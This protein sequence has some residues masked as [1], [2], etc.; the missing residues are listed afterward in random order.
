M[1]RK[2]K[3]AQDPVRAPIDRQI[4]IRIIEDN[5]RTLPPKLKRHILQ[6][7]LRR[8]LH[9]LPPNHRRAS[10]RQFLDI[11]MRRHGIADGGAVS[12]ENVDYTWRETGFVDERGHAESGERGEFGGLEDDGVAASESGTDLPAHQHNCNSKPRRTLSIPNTQKGTQKE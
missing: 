7:R 3:N 8:P 10:E 12:D 4:Q 11:H 1:E 9:D 5:I 6:V 2:E